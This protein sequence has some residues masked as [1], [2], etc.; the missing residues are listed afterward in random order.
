M[1]CRQGVGSKWPERSRDG[2]LRALR[3]RCRY[4]NRL[5]RTQAHARSA[6]R[7]CRCVEARRGHAARGRAKANGMRLARVPARAADDVLP[8]EAGFANRCDKVPGG[9]LRLERRMVECRFRTRTDALSAKRAFAT[10]EVDR[11]EGAAGVDDPWRT[12]LGALA[13]S[14]A[15]FGERGERACPR[16]KKWSGRCGRAEE[17]AAASGLHRIS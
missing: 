12:L 3:L 1:A 8:R 9:R 10:R 7:A 6:S 11:R 15:G 17:K 2:T 16:R 14:G 13:A 5:H 4:G